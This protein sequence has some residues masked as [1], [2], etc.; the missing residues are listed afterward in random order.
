[1]KSFF[2]LANNL[3]Y[4]YERKFDLKYYLNVSFSDYDNTYL[5]ELDWMYG[6]LIQTKKDENKERN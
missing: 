5:R 6:K 3:K 1:M 4:I 2:R